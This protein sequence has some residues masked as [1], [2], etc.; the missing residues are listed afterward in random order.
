MIFHFRIRNLLRIF[1]ARSTKKDINDLQKMFSH[2]CIVPF[3]GCLFGASFP[4][5]A[6][7]LHKC[8]SLPFFPAFFWHFLFKFC[9][10]NSTIHAKFQNTLLKMLLFQIISSTAP[11]STLSL[12]THC[13]AYWPKGMVTA[14][15]VG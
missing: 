5:F 14:C 8:I 12:C 9:H 3:Y 4:I 13:T 6:I 11:G 1:K 2:K 7:I 10:E 15:T